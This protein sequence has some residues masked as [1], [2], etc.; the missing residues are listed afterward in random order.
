MSLL[1][2]LSV[3]LTPCP[4]DTFVIGAVATKKLR[5]PDVEIELELHDIE[6]LNHAALDGRYDVIKVSCATYGQIS[7]RYEILETGAALTDGFG[8]MVLAREPLNRDTI[9]DLKVVAPGANTTA[10]LLF[11][12]WAGPQA[13]LSYAPYDEIIERVV[14][15][16][17]DAGVI[18]HEGR[19]TYQQ[20]GLVAVTDLGDWWRGETGRPLALGCYVMRRN[21]HALL[22]DAFDQLLRRSM[23]LAA[24]GDEDINR[25]IRRHAQEMDEAV[26]K[27]HIELYVN[28]YTRSLGTIGRDAILY[29]AEQWHRQQ[30][31]V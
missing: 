16:E 9:S 30:V 13:R 26:I 19:F 22:G 1:P 20:H 5:L 7:E 8:P 6:H 11:K 17:F 27:R 2:T 31:S 25:Y 15:G 4:N 28:D 12:S 10:A 24:A 18:I 14:D 29:L 21:L 23:A 3:A